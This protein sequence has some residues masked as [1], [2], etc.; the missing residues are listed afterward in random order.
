MEYAI[1][2]AI[3]EYN[4]IIRLYDENEYN[5]D[6][7]ILKFLMGRKKLIPLINIDTSNFPR[8]NIS[9]KNTEPMSSCKILN[10]INILLKGKNIFY[11]ELIGFENGSSVCSTYIPGLERFNLIRL[12]KEVVPQ[13]ILCK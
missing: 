3:T 11:E 8:F 1:Y 6:E 2:R 12:G 13:R 7:K 4:Q 9:I 10:N 5:D